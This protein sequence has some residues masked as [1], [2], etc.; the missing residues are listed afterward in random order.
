MLLIKWAGFLNKKSVSIVSATEK[1]KNPWL[2]FVSV[3]FSF[4]WCC[5][6][7]QNHSVKFY[8]KGRR[9]W[10]MR[11]LWWAS[12]AGK[13]SPF[14]GRFLLFPLKVS[15]YIVNLQKKVS[16]FLYCLA[17]LAISGRNKINTQCIILKICI[18]WTKCLD[19]LSKQCSMPWKAYWLI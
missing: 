9:L 6:S 2:K 17:L 4:W 13:Y 19:T 11:A 8:S 12:L 10:R 1:P 7:N 15:D 14:T 18:Y 3:L 16:E 5:I